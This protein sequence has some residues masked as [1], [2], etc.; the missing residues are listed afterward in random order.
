MLI[1]RQSFQDQLFL[2][3][4]IIVLLPA[5]RQHNSITISS[6]KSRNNTV[7]KEKGCF[8]EMMSA[9]YKTNTLNWIFIVLVH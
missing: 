3:V 5:N 6:C 1:L 4:E 2:V 8:N 9:L 7:L